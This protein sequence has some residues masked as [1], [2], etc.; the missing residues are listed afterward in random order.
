MGQFTTAGAIVSRGKQVD[1]RGSVRHAGANRIRLV[2]SKLR[3]LAPGRYVLRLR[4][5]VRG[6]WI[7]RGI[8]I[9]IRR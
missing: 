8:P 9:T 4:Q 7:D 5:R 3:A 6:Q 2:L 1:A